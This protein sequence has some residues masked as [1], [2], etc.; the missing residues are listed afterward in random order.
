MKN[1]EFSTTEGIVL[2]DLQSASMEH[3]DLQSVTP[4]AEAND[5]DYKS[6][7]SITPDYKSGVTKEK[8]KELCVP[9]WP[10]W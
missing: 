4:A 2:A 8:I 9:L 1:E 6:E 3:T 10:L 5:S 7:Y